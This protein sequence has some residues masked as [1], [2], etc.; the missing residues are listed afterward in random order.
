MKCLKCEGFITKEII[1]AENHWI[2]ETYCVNCGKRIHSDV[3]TTRQ[4]VNK[5]PMKWE[6]ERWRQVGTR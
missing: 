4:R 2:E 6:H 3:L 5:T 1:I